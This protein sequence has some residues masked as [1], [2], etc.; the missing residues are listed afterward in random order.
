MSKERRVEYLPF[1]STTPATAARAGRAENRDARMSW[2]RRWAIGDGLWA[3]VGG[4]PG[5]TAARFSAEAA[6]RLRRWPPSRQAAVAPSRGAPSRRGRSA[7]RE[8]PDSANSAT[9][10]RQRV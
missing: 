5:A 1:L 6:A 2:R 10:F 3:I 8:E 4:C 7:R 9:G